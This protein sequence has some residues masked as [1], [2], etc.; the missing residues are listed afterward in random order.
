MDESGSRITNR[1]EIVEEQICASLARKK[2]VALWPGTWPCG[3]VKLNSKT[4]LPRC[5]NHFLLWPHSTL[6]WLLN[7]RFGRRKQS[8]GRQSVEE[9][10]IPN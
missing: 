10:V 3:P 2:H 4:D 1:N 8:M 5:L 7:A 6:S 9:N